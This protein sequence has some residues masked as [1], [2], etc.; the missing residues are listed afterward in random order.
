[1]CVQCVITVCGHR[2]GSIVIL[3]NSQ[4]LTNC[5]VKQSRAFLWYTQ[6]FKQQILTPVAAVTIGSPFALAI[7]ELRDPLILNARWP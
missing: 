2:T 5:A 6:V 7:Y 3:L 1:M 4:R